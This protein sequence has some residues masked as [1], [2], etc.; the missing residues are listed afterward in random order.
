MKSY[1]FIETHGPSTVEERQAIL[2]AY[3]ELLDFVTTTFTVEFGMVLLIFVT[4]VIYHV[5]SKLR[6]NEKNVRMNNYGIALAVLG[7]VYYSVDFADWSTNTLIRE[8]NDYFYYHHNTLY[9]WLDW[10]ANSA[11]LL[12]HWFF[13]WR[14]V[15]STFRLPVLQKGA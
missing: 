4:Y 2:D 3:Y 10:S 11:Y 7:I 8:K 12:Y 14:Y 5:I 1:E 13:N 15:K 9:W 6:G